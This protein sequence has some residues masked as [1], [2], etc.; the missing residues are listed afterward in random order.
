MKKVSK[1][2]AV[3]IELIIVVLF[4]GISAI[5]TV[6]LFAKAY[7][8][9]TASTAKTQLTAVVENQMNEYRSGIASA[10]SKTLYYDNNLNEC[11]SDVAVYTEEIEAV[12]DESLP[13]IHIKVKVTNATGDNILSFDTS[14]GRQV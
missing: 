12:N 2:N 13:L 5:I 6:Q 3:L 4:F 1:V 11:A 8:I 9:E 7:S 14:Y 10:G